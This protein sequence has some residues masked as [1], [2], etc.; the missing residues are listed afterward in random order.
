MKKF[1]LSILCCLMAVFAVQAQVWTKVTDASTLKAGDQ[2][3]IA[4]DS[5]GVVAANI[6]S[7]YLSK[8]AATF[9][10]NTISSLP[11]DAVVFTLGGTTDAWTLANESA[12]LLGATAVKKVAWGS[13][14]TTWS[15]SIDVDGNATIQ[16]GTSTYGRFLYN[17]S[18]PRF[19]TYTSNA[20]ASMLLPQLYRLETSTGG[21]TPDT[22]VV[23]AP[24]A[25]T[26]P[27]ACSFDDAMTVEITGVA[28]GATAYYSLNSETDWVEGTSVEITETTTVYAKVV[29]DGL[30]SAVVSAI[31]T[32]NTPVTPPAEGEVVDVLTR[33]TTGVTGTSYTAWSG[34]SVVTSSAV[35]AGQSAGGNES[36]QLRSNNSNSGI[37]TTTSGG[38]ATKVAVVWNSNT[39]NGRTLNVYGKNEPYSAATELYSTS[40]QGTLLGTI[41]CGTSTELVIE[42]DYEYIGLR[43]ASNAMYLTSVSITW[44][45]SAGV[46]PVPP[47]SP[48]L[49]AATT[50]KGSM[51]VEITGI[52]ADATV[53]YTTDESDPVKSATRVEYTEPFEITATTTVK[54]VVLNEFGASEPATATYTLFVVEETAGYYM[55]VIAEPADWSGKYLIVYEDGT[56]AYVFNG[57]D[58]ENGYVSAT[59][60]GDVINANS[61]IDAVA[62]TVAAMEGG[63]SISTVGG[64]IYKTAYSNGMDFGDEAAVANTFAISE[65]GVVVSSGSGESKTTLRFNDASNQK[66]FRYYKSGQQPVQLYK[67][68]EELP[69]SHT[70]TVSEA[71]WA[72]LFLGFNARIPSAVEAY[73][74]TTVN[75]GWVSLTQV[76]GVLP[77]NQ[78][79]IVK[80]AAGDYKLYYETTAT[81][82]VEG[83]LLAGS[84]FNTNVEE[85]A[86]VLA[87][88]EDGVGLY[89]AK[90]T[91]GAWLNNA[92]KAYLPAS[93]VANKA[94]TFYGFEW[95]GTTGVEGV[96]AEG[97]EN[98]A[99]YDIT[100]R[101]VKAIAAPGIYIVN[102]KKVLVK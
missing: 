25:P 40:T 43:S 18:S 2:V 27:A 61:E 4:C 63:Y 21:E 79:V 48:I 50:F 95:N 97:A 52:A 22:P 41:V 20:S 36:I 96:V 90:M 77:S 55:K 84:L 100:G 31:Y 15:I 71:G 49:P 81:A 87:N 67:Y 37:V 66:R 33:E 65:E 26:L 17:N 51:M 72:T 91:D 92:N 7:Q 32:K 74:V 99:I 94:I 53:Y 76:T 45:E 98:S 56:D 68:V 9:A 62:V 80:A 69:L 28:E 11:A 16:N 73:T 47:T 54:A 78:G 13:G 83:N 93:A 39:S 82:D 70:L 8:V 42:G 29:K 6:T 3:V 44:D 64:Y 19:T 60:D 57:K 34:K 30:S 23:E 12:Q 88:G 10:D 1:L 101:R 38:K 86:Y 14:T 58:E 35:Y 102:G 5:K 75:D 85:E 89:K 59:T 24:A 46:T